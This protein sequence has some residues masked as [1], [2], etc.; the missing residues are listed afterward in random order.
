VASEVESVLDRD[1]KQVGRAT[2]EARV[3]MYIKDKINADDTGERIFVELLGFRQVTTNLTM[4]GAGTATITFENFKSA[5]MRYVSKRT[6]DMANDTS[7]NTELGQVYFDAVMNDF[8]G[9]YN[10][11]WRHATVFRGD[12]TLGV[13]RDRE[14]PFEQWSRARADLISKKHEI[15]EGSGI[16][17]FKDYGKNPSVR[18]QIKNAY[19]YGDGDG[20]LL[21]VVPFVDLFDQ[22]YVD[23]KG[24]DGFWYAGFT[25]LLTQ[26]IDSFSMTGDQSITLQC[27][28]ATVLLDNVSVVTAWNRLSVAEQNTSLLDFVYASEDNTQ[29]GKAAFVD[30]FSGN[31]NT[32]RQI[33]AKII[34][35]SQQ[36][37][38]MPETATTSGIKNVGFE[39]SPIF[40]YYGLSG[41]RVRASTKARLHVRET[42][43]GGKIG[44]MVID[45]ENFSED[46]SLTREDYI[47]DRPVFLDPLLYDMDNLFIHK[48]LSSSLSLYKDSMKSADAILN[49]LT[50]QMLAYKYIDGNGNLIIELPRYNAMPNLEIYGGR[51]YATIVRHTAEPL[52]RNP[53]AYR[54]IPSH[55]E[56]VYE[57]ADVDTS[58]GED[59]R[60]YTILFHGKNY[61]ASSDDLISFSTSI[62][63]SALV[64]VSTI[65]GVPP[66][67]AD[68]PDALISSTK[69]Y[70]A[71][72]T[73]D[74]TWLAKLGVRRYAVQNLYNVKWRDTEDANKVLSYMA[75][76]ILERVNA[77]ADSGTIQLSHRPDIQL[78]RT[79]I[80]PLR[81]KSYL[82]MGVTNTWSPG[83]PHTTTLQV[84]YGH[85]IHKALDYPW[86]A[87]KVE[88]DVFLRTEDINKTRSLDKNG[89]IVPDDTKLQDPTQTVFQPINE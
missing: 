42:T 64:T 36:M 83:S 58:T 48:L 7:R 82:V 39:V 30:Y 78:G 75:S 9:L 57:Q 34:D 33:I 25:G 53:K 77:E 37:W 17:E 59:I 71:V 13:D 81:W 11:F 52:V 38:Q 8:D 56:V 28:D 18:E 22:I 45:P 43:E 32:I 89:Q 66:F 60:W 5:R 46:F 80:N 65:R 50:A 35:V 26:I 40:K 69:Q 16:P 73:S 3:Y 87:I 70:E 27:K 6:I 62:D 72:A 2:P 84:S 19:P 29:S 85:P 68:L 21:Y 24:Q 88:P 79:F 67:L 41:R 44:E 49:G 76:V 55:T 54:V 63:E 10:K 51:S 23:F 61:V 20:S 14:V 74:I 12:K 15:I 4:K 47:Y 31:F 86:S 1:Y